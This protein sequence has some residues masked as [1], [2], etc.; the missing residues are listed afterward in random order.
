MTG[1]FLGKEIRHIPPARR[2]GGACFQMAPPW[3]L[4]SVTL[5]KVSELA[6]HIVAYVTKDHNM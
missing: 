3:S 4:I 1:R 5:C 2:A 6:L